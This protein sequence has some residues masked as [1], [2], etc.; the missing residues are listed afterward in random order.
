MQVAHQE[1]RFYAITYSAE[2]AVWK[3]QKYKPVEITGLYFS[4]FQNFSKI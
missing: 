3:G 1:G 2:L 4:I